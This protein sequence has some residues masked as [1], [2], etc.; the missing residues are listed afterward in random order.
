MPTTTPPATQPAEPM[1][2]A[3]RPSRVIPVAL[4]G[5]VVEKLGSLNPAT[6]RPW[7]SRE[8]SAWLKEAHGVKASRMSVLRVQAHASDKANALVIEAIRAE[9][10]DD[11]IPAR[12]KLMRA[13]RHLDAIT[14]DSTSVKD[15]AASVSAT[16]RALHELAHLGGVAAPVQVDLT[17]GGA[18]LKIYLPDET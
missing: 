10:R 11:V 2:A 12:E 15:V 4:Q 1:T 5:E 9:L 3:T 18:T 6:G 16:T 14:R 17:S 7:T 13:L 8:V